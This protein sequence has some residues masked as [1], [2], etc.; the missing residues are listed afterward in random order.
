MIKWTQ[1]SIIRTLHFTNLV[2][3]Q[4]RKWPGPPWIITSARSVNVASLRVCW[5][6]LTFSPSA[7]L[8]PTTTVPGCSAPLGSMTKPAAVTIN[9]FSAFLFPVRTTKVINSN[10]RQAFIYWGKVR[11]EIE[12]KSKRHRNDIETISKR[13]QNCIG[14]VKSMVIRHRFDIT[15]ITL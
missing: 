8:V 9:C 2:L 12:T 15:L 6:C 3:E 7:Y 13:C 14:S 1:K 11:L 10:K 5:C 4:I